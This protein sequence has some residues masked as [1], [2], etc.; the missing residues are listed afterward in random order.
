[1]NLVIY[2]IR[3]YGLNIKNMRKLKIMW[4]KLKN[5]FKIIDSDF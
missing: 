4:L 5:I 1:M 3:G 2:V